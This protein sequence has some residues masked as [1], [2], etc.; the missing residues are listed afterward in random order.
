MTLTEWIAKYE[1]KTG[2][3]FSMPDGF[4]LAFDL[5]HGFFVFG[6]G[7]WKGKSWLELKQTCVNDWQWLRDCV[8]ES[9]YANKLNGVLATTN[10]NHKAYSKLTGAKYA[11]TL[12]D[13]RHVLI[14]EVSDV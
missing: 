13:G 5:D 12:A 3:Q 9:V 2:E 4:Q 7:E 8:K 1:K 11:E 14:W 10:R 6:F